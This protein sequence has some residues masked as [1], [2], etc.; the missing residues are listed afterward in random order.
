MTWMLES[1]IAGADLEWYACDK[2][3]RIAFL[4]SFMNSR[5]PISV[6]S[7]SEDFYVVAEYFGQL[8]VVCE[9]RVIR[10]WDGDQRDWIEAAQRGLFAFDG[11][12]V[13][14]SPAYELVAMPSVPINVRVLQPNIKDVISR[15]RA[16]LFFDEIVAIDDD[17][18]FGELTRG[19]RL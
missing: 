14:E 17:S 3:G 16:P 7:N 8:P 9:A 6:A 2:E 11:S 19:R 5:I 15:T 13:G 4:T 12:G 18:I 10:Q 1:E